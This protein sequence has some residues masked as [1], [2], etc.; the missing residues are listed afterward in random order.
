MDGQDKGLNVSALLKEYRRIRPVVSVLDE[1]IALYVYLDSGVEEDRLKWLF[2][3]L[4][5]ERKKY[6][7]KGIPQEQWPKILQGDD[8]EKRLLKDGRFALL[9]TTVSPGFEFAD[10]ESGRRDELVRFYPDFRDL[11]IALT[12]P[13]TI[14]PPPTAED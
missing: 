6:Q 7:E 10:Y 3:R 8:W 13:P 5:R 1:L 2:L 11:I 12:K 9:G 14:S 4:A